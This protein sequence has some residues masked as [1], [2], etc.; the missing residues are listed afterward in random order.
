MNSQR[1]GA[2]AARQLRIA[3]LVVA[4]LVATQLVGAGVNQDARYVL[5]ALRAGRD[6]GWSA[7]EIWAHRPLAARELMAALEVLT[8]DGYRL[9]EAVLRGWCS[10]LAVAAA[11]LF[12]RGLHRHGTR[13]R[14]VAP[15]ISFGVG[16]ALVLAPGWDFAE[17]EWFALVFAVAGIGVVLTWTDAVGVGLAGILLAYAGLLKY[18]TLSTVL[19][20][21]GV[22]WCLDR[23]LA[24]RTALATAVATVLGF[25]VSVWI[26]PHEWQWLWDMP[27]LNPPASGSLLKDAIEGVINSLVVSPVTV[28]AVVGAALLVRRHR[29]QVGWLVAG[30]AVAY[31][32]YP[33]QHQNFLYHQAAVAV[34]SAGFVAW[35]MSVAG[36]AA[37]RALL[38]TAV[39]APLAAAALFVPDTA[40]RS[41]PLAAAVMVLVAGLGVA[42]GIVGARR[43]GAAKPR[44]R[45]WLVLITLVA[46]LLVTVSPATAYSYSLAHARVTSGRN[47]AAGKPVQVPGLPRGARI[48]YFGFDTPYR[49][50]NPSSCR[51]VSPTFLQR[52]SGARAAPIMQTRSFA[53]NLACLDDPGAA[54]AVI[55]PTWFAPGKVDERVRNGFERNFD[56]GKTLSGTGVYACR[57]R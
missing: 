17:P 12:G 3:S 39:A 2:P 28:V 19:I 16:A 31:A 11:Y 9:Q 55:D 57:R 20:A 48:V 38:L 15:V 42:L 40:R 6:A 24:L 36:P 18:T 21:L 53:E 35:A 8:P 43:H 4:G 14:Q 30:W 33:V 26:E 10:L 51:Y 54:Y 41:V 52:A 47:V 44:L 1:G 23:A 45:P 22:L 37:R 7:S 56:C 34:L 32:P 5:G 29:A 46:P 13:V 27:R 49:L 50:G 25:A